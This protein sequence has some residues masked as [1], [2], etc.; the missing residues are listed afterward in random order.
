M[1]G[2]ITGEHGVG[3]EKDRLMPLLFTEA[4][5]DVMR[6]VRDAFN[7]QGLLNPEKIFPTKKGCGEIHVRPLPMVGATSAPST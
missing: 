1:G 2:S 3:M 6:R 4:E 7:P 5:L